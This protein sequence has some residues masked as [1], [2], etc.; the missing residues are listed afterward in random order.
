[1]IDT[2]QIVHADA[3][4][5][6]AVHLTVPRIDIQKV[7]GPA[8]GEVYAALAAQSIAPTGPWFTYHLQ[9]PSYLFNFEACVPV[10]T[11]V[12][13]IGRVKNTNRPA[14]RVARTVYHGDY[15]GLAQAWGELRA[16]IASNGHVPAQQLWECY[17]TDPQMNPDPTTWRTE[18]NQPLID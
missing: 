3:Q 7:M 10:A 5:A 14:A 1:M 11:P 17:L 16:W 2:P 4:P 9:T 15:Q 13:P 6:A 18:L 8:I 12:A